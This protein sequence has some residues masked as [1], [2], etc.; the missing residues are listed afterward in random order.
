MS[1]EKIMKKH[2]LVDIEDNACLEHVHAY[3]R[4]A[5]ACLS[6]SPRELD[7]GLELHRDAMALDTFGFMPGVWTA[8]LV[9][10]LD[11]LREGHIG[12]RE[13][14]FRSIIE[15]MAAPAEDPDGPAGRTWLALLR[16]SGLKGMVATV[17]RAMV[18]GMNCLEW[19]L[20]YFAANQHLSGAFHRDLF[21]ARSAAHLRAGVESGRFGVIWSMNSPPVP[22][23][24]I[25][26]LDEFSW[27]ETFRRLGFRLCHLGYNRR[28]MAAD[29]G[30]EEA[31]GGLSVFGYELIEQLNEVG[32]VVDT[33][34]SGPRTTLQAA[35]ASKRP[36]MAS[37]VGCRALFD[38]HRN[39]SDEELRAIAGTGGLAGMVGLGIFLGHEAD[40]GTLLDH[41]DHAVRVAGIDHVA[42]GTD[43]G[44]SVPPPETLRGYP[45]GRGI[46]RSGW[47]GAWREGCA[48]RP[49]ARGE[50]TLKWT[51]WPLFTV[52][53]VQRGYRDEDIRKL[54]GLN[55]LRVLEASEPKVESGPALCGPLEERHG[56]NS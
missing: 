8:R 14:H 52:G 15:R 44:G 18:P 26:P 27:L 55:L 2:P 30:A 35:A 51:N 48:A 33:P 10:K 40:L 5:L 41:V 13:Y 49:C 43:R 4:A 23:R 46:F 3:W 39:K 56:G 37:H 28:N 6:P 17:G 24:M 53:L 9:E 50:A 45:P 19:D 7:H 11:A 54:L 42:I 38:H 47:T 32:I 31:D 16:A 29:G 22:E 20:A 12:R 21:Q 25:D 34:H 1:V 36:I